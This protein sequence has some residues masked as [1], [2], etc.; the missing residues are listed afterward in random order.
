MGDSAVRGKRSDIGLAKA[1]KA[2]KEHLTN[3]CNMCFA[4]LPS[5]PNGEVLSQEGARKAVES[6][7]R[8]YYTEMLRYKA[9]PKSSKINTDLKRVA[10]AAEKAS[11][12]LIEAN[13]Q[14]KI[15]NN[16]MNGL[17]EDAIRRVG[18][19][20]S[21]IL[22]ILNESKSVRGGLLKYSYKKAI[23]TYGDAVLSEGDR[24]VLR[25]EIFRFL[26]SKRKSAY[27]A[28]LDEEHISRIDSLKTVL[29][30]AATQKGVG[31]PTGGPKRVFQEASLFPSY[32]L[33]EACLAIL[34]ASDI[35]PGTARKGA[36]EELST[37]IRMRV[38]GEHAPALTRAIE[39]LPN[40]TKGQA[41][42]LKQRLDY[43]SMG[44]LL[45][46]LKSIQHP[47]QQ[48][49]ARI[50]EL[51]AQRK[52]FHAVLCRSAVLKRVLLDGELKLVHKFEPLKDID[53][54]SPFR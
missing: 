7:A 5:S 47:D 15:L 48:T 35:P 27:A 17:G 6:A 22:R 3:V 16:L 26:A 32:Q 19:V 31:N 53:Q 20:P 30:E 34:Q 8:H 49:S 54:E 25:S 41:K 40:K 1:T 46:D 36:L 39:G 4:E 52:I 23:L 13:K 42:R 10:A 24:H 45:E 18:S 33:V 29:A 2:D 43:W 14:L 51:E 38:E 28:V 21:P 11:A 12:C 44:L 50:A 37:A 9:S